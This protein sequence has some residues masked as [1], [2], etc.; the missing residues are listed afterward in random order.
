[1]HAVPLLLEAD[2]HFY[3]IYLSKHACPDPLKGDILPAL[4]YLVVGKVSD[5]LEKVVIK[6]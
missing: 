6:H 1:M 2:R 4:L 5:G 3:Q